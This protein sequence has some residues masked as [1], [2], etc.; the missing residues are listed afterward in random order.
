[1]SK[2]VELITNVHRNK[3]RYADHVDL[4]TRPLSDV[5][6]ALNGLD[7]DFDLDR[8]TG[9]QLDIIGE[10]VGRNRRITAPIDDYFFTLDSDSLGFDF[11][12]W[13]GRYTPDNGAIDVGD[14][15]FRAM[16][17]ARIG[18]NNW[19][20]TVESLTP[21]LDGIYPDGNIKLSFTDNQDMTMSIYVNG[22]V[23]SGITKEIIRQGFLSIKP[24]GVSVTYVING[25]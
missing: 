4:S 21:V 8:A 14:T 11:G 18:A 20:G 15:E 23:I 24:A 1:M 25:E 22:S 10:W 12:T 6:A 9:A 19:D 17:R 2:Y 7:D 16:L 13:K 5:S 3:S